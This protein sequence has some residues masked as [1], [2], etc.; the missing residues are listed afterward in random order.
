MDNHAGT[1]NIYI[2]INQEESKRFISQEESKI[3]TSC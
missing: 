2:N 3:F 1:N